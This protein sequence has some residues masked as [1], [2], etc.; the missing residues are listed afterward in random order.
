MVI[1]N[2]SPISPQI[3]ER[4]VSPPIA[5]THLQLPL[6][7]PTTLVGDGLV[8]S[9]RRIHEKLCSGG[10]G[11]RGPEVEGGGPH[12]LGEIIGDLLEYLP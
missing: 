8:A 1:T 4:I 6:L 12:I 7:S 3:K 9:G 5:G 2:I 10:Y 11:H